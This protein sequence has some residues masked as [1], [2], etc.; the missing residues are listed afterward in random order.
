MGK[1]LKMMTLLVHASF[2][3][4]SGSWTLTNNQLDNLR[5]LHRK[6]LRTMIGMKRPA[7]M[8]VAGSMIKANDSMSNIMNRHGMANLGS[9]FSMASKVQ[10]LLSDAP[11]AV[12]K[13]PNHTH[14]L[15]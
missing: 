5:G 8:T 2:I 3:W 14:V 10:T 7:E 9:I 4:C 15:C 6:M 12:S 13:P 11:V 1:R